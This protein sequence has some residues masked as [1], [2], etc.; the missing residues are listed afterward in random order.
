MRVDAARAHGARRVGT[1]DMQRDAVTPRR[2]GGRA[3]GGHAHVGGEHGGRRAAQRGEQRGERRLGQL[4]RLAARARRVRVG[5]GLLVALVFLMVIPALVAGG[6]DM[7]Q[8]AAS[9]TTALMAAAAEGVER[10]K[11]ARG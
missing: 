1:R 8:A 2:L 3:R 10:A 4:G 9:G 7:N 6:C 11:A 5:G